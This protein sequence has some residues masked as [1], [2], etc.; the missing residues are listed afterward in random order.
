[1]ESGI[2]GIVLFIIK[3]DGNATGV[4][5][6]NIFLFIQSETSEMGCFCSSSRPIKCAACGSVKPEKQHSCNLLSAKS[7]LRLGSTTFCQIKQLMIYV[8]KYLTGLDLLHFG[9]S[10]KINRRYLWKNRF[11]PIGRLKTELAR[12]GLSSLPTILRK[13]HAILVGE[14]VLAAITNS[15]E[16][17]RNWN[18]QID[19][20]VDEYY[21]R[22][23]AS[24]LESLIGHNKFSEIR[25]RYYS[26]TL[27][28]LQ[29]EDQKDSKEKKE[30]LV[31]KINL[32]VC[33]PRF[34]GRLTCLN[35]YYDGVKLKVRDR[36]AALGRICRWVVRSENP[37]YEW[38][39]ISK[40]ISR[41]FVVYFPKGSPESS[42]V[43]KDLRSV[44]EY[45]IEYKYR[46]GMYAHEAWVEHEPM[47]WFV[48]EIDFF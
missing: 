9:M 40:Y 43:I 46:T 35:N 22:R 24:S 13:H 20:N 14:M 32:H 7:D 41:G 19:I 17:P 6:K 30:L 29:E 8:A 25:E 12:L 36:E 47:V 10:C 1:M 27:P 44:A 26:M 45:I 34:F 2:V 5:H 31:T 38:D 16:V 48:D 39:F 28:A 18:Y 37:Q 21:L 11:T 3:Q 33:W 42:L 15:I 4:D 23:L